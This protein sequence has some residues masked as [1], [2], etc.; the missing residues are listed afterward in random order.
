MILFCDENVGSGVAHALRD[1]GLSAH[2]TYSLGWM[3]RAD[4]WWLPRVGEAGWVVFSANKK[5][6]LVPRE[7]QTI[8]EN[9]VGII[10]LTTGNETPRT[11]LRLLL[12]RWDRLE[13]L[14]GNTAR[15]FARF[16]SPNGRLADSFR[17]YHL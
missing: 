14:D 9:E 1:V 12:N 16:L 10:F 8:I 7:R 15:P 4:E 5:M 17:H 13:S 6:L 11:M 2:S 3:G